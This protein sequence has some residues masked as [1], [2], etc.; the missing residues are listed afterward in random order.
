MRIIQQKKKRI[1]LQM[2][3][4]LLLFACTIADLLLEFCEEVEEV[5]IMGDVTYGA[6]CIDDFTAVA[7]GCD[8]LVHYG[9]SC[10]V[11]IDITT[12]SVLYVFV[13]IKMDVQH[14]ID[15]VKHNVSSDSKVAF[16][17]TIQFAASLHNAK[18]ELSKY[19]GASNILVPQSLPLSPGEVLGCTSPRLPE[20]FKIVVCLGDGRFHLESVMIHNSKTVDKFY[21]YDPYSKIFTTEEY[22]YGRMVSVRWQAIEKAK[23]ASKIGVV[24]G[25]LGR[26]GNPNILKHITASLAKADKDFVVVLLSEIIPS[27]LKKFKEI[28]AWVQVACPRLSVDWGAYFGGTPVLNSY[29]ASVCFGGAEWCGEEGTETYPMDYYSAGGGEWSNAE[30]FNRKKK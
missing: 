16:V 26:Q 24:L 17:C 30:R 12:I 13:D 2:P 14:F 9:H 7:L 19:F 27:K 25:T 21:K 23:K 8:L 22:D 10:L 18:I 11:P 28:E 5:V 15:T 6:C 4:G 29:E 20:D 1:A 3:E